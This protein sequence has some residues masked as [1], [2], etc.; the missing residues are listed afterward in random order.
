MQGS[1]IFCLL[2]L[3]CGWDEI[4]PSGLLSFFRARFA[5]FPDSRLSS[6]LFRLF[7]YL[8]SFLLFPCASV[9]RAL[10]HEF[11]ISYSHTERYLLIFRN[12][13]AVINWK[14][15]AIKQILLPL[16]HFCYSISYI[17]FNSSLTACFTELDN[18][19]IRLFATEML[20]SVLLCVKLN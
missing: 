7:L 6:C 9:G 20:L 15:G 1:A 4:G 8:V 2:V 11:H 17:R 12:V 14:R 19:L 3:C 10:V 16:L 18:L 5:F 13:K